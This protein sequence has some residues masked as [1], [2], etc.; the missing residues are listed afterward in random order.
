MTQYPQPGQPGPSD[1]SQ[2]SGQPYGQPD[3]S[4]G[5]PNQPYAQYPGPQGQPGPQ[6]PPP[7]DPPVPQGP[8]GTVALT[9]Q[10]SVMTSNMITP[11][12]KI[13]GH[14]IPTRY[15]LQQIP[16][17]AGPVHVEGYAQWM[18]TYGQA[19]LDFTMQAGQTVPVFYAAPM[20]QFTTGSIGHEQQKRKGVGAM[21]AIIIGIVLFVA[22]LFGIGAALA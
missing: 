4:Y 18:R 5:Q 2:P 20:H 11:S 6:D 21:I 7:Q 1:P 10:G 19:A 22:L 17:P 16:V 9:I 14:Q 15:G 12:I 3:Q 8:M 13:N